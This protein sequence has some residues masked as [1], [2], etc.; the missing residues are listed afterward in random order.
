MHYS[1]MQLT[2]SE[3][4]ANMCRVF[5]EELEIPFHRLSPHVGETIGTAEVDDAK[6]CDSIIW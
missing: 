3:D 1:A 6:L 2:K 4:Q 5:C